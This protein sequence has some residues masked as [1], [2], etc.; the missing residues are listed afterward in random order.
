MPSISW[1]SPIF[2]SWPALSLFIFFYFLSWAIATASWQVFL[3][4]WSCHSWTYSPCQSLEWP[5]KNASLIMSHLLQT[6][7]VP[8]HQQGWPG[9]P[10][11][12][13]QALSL[14]TSVLPFIFIRTEVLVGLSKPQAPP[15]PGFLS[16]SC[17]FFKAQTRP[18][19][20][21]FQP[22]H[23]TPVTALPLH[24]STVTWAFSPVDCDL[25]GWHR[26]CSYR[27]PKSSQ[28]SEGDKHSS[29]NHVNGYIIKIALVHTSLTSTHFLSAYFMPGSMSDTGRASVNK[30][31]TLY[32]HRAHSL[33]R[34]IDTNR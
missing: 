22:P 31:Q 23:N 16:D 4:F 13:S 28:S 8:H 18:V 10:R 14:T 5:V 15:R 12:P 7:V 9:P 24:I 34:R 2:S 27:S 32:V 6:L 25:E 1:T 3:H 19:N 33:S 26:V 29:N 30:K 20:K 11:L 21:S 17:S